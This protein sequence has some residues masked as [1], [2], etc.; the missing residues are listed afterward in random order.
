MFF[1]VVFSKHLN[2]PIWLFCCQNIE[3]FLEGIHNM[4]SYLKIIN[5]V[6][7][8]LYLLSTIIINLTARFVTFKIRFLTIKTFKDK[9]RDVC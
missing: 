9:Y 1:K 5:N 6:F 7:E 2:F 4:I 8:T 3:L